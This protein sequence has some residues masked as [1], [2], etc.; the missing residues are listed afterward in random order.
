MSSRF[1]LKPLAA[2]YI[3]T[4]YRPPE[5][6]PMSV[7]KKRVEL[8]EDWNSLVFAS[9][10]SNIEYVVD[11]IDVRRGFH[12]STT[13]TLTL[14]SQV[15]ELARLRSAKDRAESEV[16]AARNERSLASDRLERALQA[17]NRA[18]DALKNFETDHG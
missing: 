6:T 8:P 14:R 10:G 3:S 17:K 16:D 4:F 7:P 13:I 11:N 18:R 2:E 15:N 9:P 1:N 12:L 5:E